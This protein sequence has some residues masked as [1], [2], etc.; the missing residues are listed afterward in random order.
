MDRVMSD[1]A[2]V[3]QGTRLED[4][5]DRIRWREVVETAKVLHGLKKANN[6][7]KKTWKI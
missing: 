2:E 4:S 7:K 1:L 3:S 6:K 5:E